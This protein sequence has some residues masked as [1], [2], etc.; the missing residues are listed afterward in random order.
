MLTITGAIADHTASLAN[1]AGNRRCAPSAL[2]RLDTHTSWAIQVVV[3]VLEH[4]RGAG[5]SI[6]C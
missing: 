1:V 4:S 3:P 5:T 2:S 6:C